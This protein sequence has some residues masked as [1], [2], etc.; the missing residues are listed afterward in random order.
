[1]IA[2]DGGAIGVPEVDLTDPAVATDPVAAYGAAR[3]KGPVARLTAPGLELWAVTR[4]EDARGML[5]DRR[6]R[7]RAD[8]Y[9]R[10][11]VP[12]DCVP[13]LRT[14]QEMEGAGHTRLRRLAHRVVWVNPRRAAPGP[15]GCSTWPSS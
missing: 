4:H 9:Q 11:D 10:P 3:E 5:T 2:V 1:M 13:Y 7:L 15:H 8:S 14:M 12:D 6:F